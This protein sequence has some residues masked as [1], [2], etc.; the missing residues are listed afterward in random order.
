M[1]N[2]SCSCD[3]S[4]FLQFLD[5]TSMSFFSKSTWEESTLFFKS[6]SFKLSSCSTLFLFSLFFRCQ[7]LNFFFQIIY[8][9]IT[10][11]LF[12]F[13]RV[14]FVT[15]ASQILKSWFAFVP[16]CFKIFGKLLKLIKVC[17]QSSN[18]WLFCLH[19]RSIFL[20]VI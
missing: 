2:F 3:T 19:F 8:L 4:S 12:L 1:T 15:V 13:N 10:L 20:S 18:F 17:F 16:I 7:S 5:S 11:W 6:I 14:I 9:I